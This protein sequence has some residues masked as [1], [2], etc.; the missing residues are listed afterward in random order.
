M[1]ITSISVPP[2]VQES[3]TLAPV[4]LDCEYSIA[5]SEKQGL[6]VQW[7]L[8]DLR[9]PVYQ[10]IP[11]KRPQDLGPLKG[12]LNLEYRATEDPYHRHRALQILKPSADLAGEYRCKVATFDS[13]DVQSANMVVYGKLANFQHS[14]FD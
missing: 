4:V 10:W 11:G 12:R 1:R 13:E 9:A 3:S 2:A 7:F 14:H 6:V 8:R 5:D